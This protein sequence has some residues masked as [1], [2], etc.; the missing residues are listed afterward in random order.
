[1]QRIRWCRLRYALKLSSLLVACDATAGSLNLSIP[2]APQSYQSD[3]IRSGDI[4]CKNAIGGATN[5]EFGVT[6][7]VNS[8]SSETISNT[9]ELGDSGFKDIGV[10]ARII[11]PIDGPKERINCNTLDQLE[12][13]KKRLEVQMLK[14][15]LNQLRKLG[16]GGFEN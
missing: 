1:M 3:S 8:E 12:L 16:N 10:Y 11:I 13:Q 9:Y 15:E 6:G 14:Q 4:D 2:T 5:V 7:I